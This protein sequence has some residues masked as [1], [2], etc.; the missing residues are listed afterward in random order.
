MDGLLRTR[1]WIVCKAEALGTASLGVVDQSES[2]D[3][4]GAGKNFGNLLLRKT[5]TFL[6]SYLKGCLRASARCSAPYGMLP[7]KT[8]REGGLEDMAGGG[9][10]EKLWKAI[11][12]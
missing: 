8:T 11:D 10:K 3:L 5:C 2:L 7:T 4:A 12:S 6:V 9:G 1:V